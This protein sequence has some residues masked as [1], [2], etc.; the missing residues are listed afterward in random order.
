MT[1][2]TSAT[3]CKR[4]R[5]VALSTGGNE[6]RFFNSLVRIIIIHI[7]RIASG[8]IVAEGVRQPAQS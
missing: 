5:Y 8:A 1:G 7:S 6:P 3:P 4:R 2:P